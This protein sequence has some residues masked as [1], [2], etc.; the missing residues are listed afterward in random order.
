MQ[1]VVSM[2]L[3]CYWCEPNPLD[4]M[5]TGYTA[6]ETAQTKVTRMFLHSI[7]EYAQHTSMMARIRGYQDIQGQEGQISSTALRSIFA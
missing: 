3:C 1:H 2:F 7:Q 6:I 5:Q 4:I